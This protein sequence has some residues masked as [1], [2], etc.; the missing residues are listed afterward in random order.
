MNEHK[1]ESKVGARDCEQCDRN[2]IV[3]L[4]CND[5]PNQKFWNKDT[6]DWTDNL[7]NASID[8]TYGD[9]IGTIWKAIPN[10]KVIARITS[11]PKAIYLRLLA[12]EKI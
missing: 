5:I 8:Y 12:R 10:N 9:A 2:Y 1:C 3:I 11:C 7:D 6:Q 4:V